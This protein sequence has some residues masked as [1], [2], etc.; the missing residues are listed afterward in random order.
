ME[1]KR[2]R[3]KNTK[4]RILGVRASLLIHFALRPHQ[5]LLGS[6]VLVISKHQPLLP[7]RVLGIGKHNAT[8][9][10]YRTWNEVI[11]E[12]WGVRQDK[13]ESWGT[14]YHDTSPYGRETRTVT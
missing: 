5:P 13:K 2:S 12:S 3:F 1:K 9:R 8:T 10:D 14:S 11:G 4:L 6:T 7:V